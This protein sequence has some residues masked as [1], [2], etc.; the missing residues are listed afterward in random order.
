MKEYIAYMDGIAVDDALRARV[1]R[2]AAHFVKPRRRHAPRYV[3]WT[4][5][6]AVITLC[7]WGISSNKAPSAVPS[8]VPS[9]PI[10][11]SATVAAPSPTATPA[12]S[13]TP[14]AIDPLILNRAEAQLSALI[15]IPGHFWYALT[16]EQRDVVLP[17]FDFPIAATAHYSGEGELHHITAYEVDT[18]GQA[19]TFGEYHTRTEIVLAP[20]EII[21]DIV[22]N[23]QPE[24][25]DV[26]GITILAGVL[27]HD[28]DDGTAFY[29][30]SFK[31]DGIAYSVKLNDSEAGDRGKTRLTE[32]AGAIVRHG[33]PDLR[34]LGDPVI[35]RLRDETL[36]LEEAYADPDFGAFIPREP[37]AG[38]TLESARRFLNQESD[39]LQVSWSLGYDYLTWSASVPTQYEL[40]NIVGPEEREQYD[41]ALYP[42]PHADT[43]PEELRQV[44]DNPVFRSEELTPEMI[45]ARAYQLADKGDT[46]GWRMH[47]GVLYGDVIV[48]VSAKGLSPDRVYAM[49][50]AIP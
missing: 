43:V 39:S 26:C 49:L 17:G 25:S 32:I 38:Y 7:V 44:V 37:P 23:Y 5:C 18:N 35:P 22:Y 13:A 41:L 33:A 11:R 4:A 50:A 46:P 29:V 3:A 36:T 2:S 40:D 28:P 34:I 9:A 16:D 42:I 20:G 47:F 27:D 21:D 10:T 48:Q 31:M 6:A 30:A 8:P 1:L 12:P 14:E 19:A 24:M 15:R 45:R